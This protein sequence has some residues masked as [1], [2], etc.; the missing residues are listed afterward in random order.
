M[1]PLPV[2][3][4]QYVKDEWL[5]IKVQRLVVQEELGQQTQVLTVNLKGWGWVEAG[6]GGRQNAST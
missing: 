4:G 6:S 2:H 3:L 5:H 1:G